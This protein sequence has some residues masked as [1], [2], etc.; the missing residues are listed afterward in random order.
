M[1]LFHKK[2]LIKNNKIINKCL[3]ISKNLDALFINHQRII[4]IKIKIYI[5]LYF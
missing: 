4:I 2:E 3:T 1:N 5:N